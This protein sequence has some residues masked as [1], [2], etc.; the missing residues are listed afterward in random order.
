MEEIEQ[1]VKEKFGK[2]IYEYRHKH[3][4]KISQEML[5]VQIIRDSNSKH[6]KQEIISQLERSKD[7]FLTEKDIL[8]IQKICS[9]SDEI[10]K[11][12][13][14]MVKLKYS[15]KIK[16]NLVCIREHEYLLTKN[17][18][19]EITFY[20]GDYFCYFHS[21]A[22][23]ENKIV[24]GIMSILPFHSSNICEAKFVI[25]EDEKAIKEY[26]GQFF[27]NTLYD[28]TYCILVCDEKQETSFLISNHFNASTRK[29]NLFNLALVLTTSAGTTKLPTMHRMLISR[30][31]LSQET[32]EILHSQLGLNTD[33][34]HISETKL[35]ELEAYYNEEK[36]NTN[37]EDYLYVCNYILKTINFIRK[38]TIKETYY[39]IDETTIYNTNT[40]IP[41]QHNNYIH[42]MVISALRKNTD[43]A[44]NNK[45]DER[46]AE[47]CLN[48]ISYQKDD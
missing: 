8:S 15:S 1:R 47:I 43:I 26:I 25:Y 19:S 39:T 31:K 13:I 4:Q 20:E 37:D 38:S 35:N 7:V 27:L 36:N 32:V 9:I 48:I 10:V 46:V 23:N 28:M 2:A 12:Y 18:H 33:A 11:P 5:A 16:E 40:I 3:S 30:K 34:I 21:T 44:F 24:S 17:K 22:S 14:E 42:S 29:H 45:I 6:I 41:K